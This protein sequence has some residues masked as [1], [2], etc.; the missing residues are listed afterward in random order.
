MHKH[1]ALEKNVIF[2]VVPGSLPD[3]DLAD[4]IRGMIPEKY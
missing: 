1:Y 4:P 2:A 3:I